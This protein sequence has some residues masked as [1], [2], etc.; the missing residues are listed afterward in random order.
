[1]S[2]DKCRNKEDVVYIKNG[3]LLSRKN[4]ITPLAATWMDLEVI[5]SEMR[6]KEREKY[7][8]LSLICGI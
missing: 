1:M 3:I 6:Q 8:L 2:T 4:G 5:L 7:H